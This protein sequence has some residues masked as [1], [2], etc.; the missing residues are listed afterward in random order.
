MPTRLWNRTTQ[1]GERELT[2]MSTPFSLSELEAWT[3]DRAR[4]LA[5]L[6]LSS[7]FLSQSLSFSPHPCSQCSGD[8]LK[9]RSWQRLIWATWTTYR[10][11]V[12]INKTKSIKC[13]KEGHFIRPAMTV[14]W[15]T[16]K[17]SI[18]L[19]M[20]KCWQKYNY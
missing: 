15:Q 16:C 8:K 4:N 1:R 7:C 6:I 2:P 18:C 9:M 19:K 13:G 5:F 12:A 17:I 3:T 10:R 20:R 14:V 11:N